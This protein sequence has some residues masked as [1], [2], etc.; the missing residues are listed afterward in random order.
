MG[1]IGDKDADS[2]GGFGWFFHGNEV[3][4]L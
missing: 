1:V 3:L 4:V 2:Q